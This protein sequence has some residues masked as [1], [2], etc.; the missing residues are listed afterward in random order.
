MGKFNSSDGTNFLR[1]NEEIIKCYARYLLN[2]EIISNEEFQYHVTDPVG[3]TE[4]LDIL[5]D[6]LYETEEYR[7][8]QVSTLDSFYHFCEFVI[9]E[10]NGQKVWNNFVKE[11]FISV[12]LNKDT[13]IMASRSVGKSFFNF[14]LYPLF[15]MFLHANTKFLHVSN[16]PMQCIENL[17]ITKNVIDSNEMLYQKKEVWKGKEL[18]WTERQIEYNKGMFVTVSAGTSPKGLHVN[19]VVVDDIL[20]EESQ[21][22]DIEMENYIFGQLYPTIQRQ[23]GRMIVTG[24]PLHAKDIYHLLMGSSDNFEGDAIRDGRISYKG[25]F[26]KAFPIVDDEERLLLPEI[27]DRE[28]IEKIRIKVGEIKFQREYLLRPIDSSVA[29]FNEHLISSVSSKDYHYMYSA[30][31]SQN[32]FLI[33][34]DVATSGAASADYS[35]FIVLELIPTEKGRR[36]VIRHIIHVKGMPINEQVNTVVS[37]SRSFNN[38]KV[39]VEKNNVGVALIQELT[40]MNINVEEFVTT[41]DKKHGMIRYLETELK[42]GNLWFCEETENITKL[43]KEMMNFGVKVSRAGKERMEALTGHDD[44]VMS[45]AMANQAAQNRGSLAMAILQ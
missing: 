8:I 30:G 32:L 42:N 17:R 2:Q 38:A 3:S 21:L 25:F 35:A 12:E 28:Q 20:T 14:V 33:G 36:K 15:K 9:H 13:C 1:T 45:L 23:K 44:L 19:F 37:L 16:I 39:I 18:K 10:Y 29:I 11:M 26:S 31:D 6:K 4:L 34:V 22:N 5:F 43:K 40:K 7:G 27:Y 24:T 41:Q